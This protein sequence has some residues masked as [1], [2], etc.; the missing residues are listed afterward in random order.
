MCKQHTSNAL[1]KHKDASDEDETPLAE[2]TQQ[3]IDFLSKDQ[4]RVEGLTGMQ[5][6]DAIDKLKENFYREHMENHWLLPSISPLLSLTAYE[7][8]KTRENSST[9]TNGGTQAGMLL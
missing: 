6:L 5:L 7:L 2:S 9:E 8:E 1:I 4:I 3:E